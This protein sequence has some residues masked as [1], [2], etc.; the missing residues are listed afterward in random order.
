MSGTPHR[1]LS[2][3]LSKRI[4]LDITDGVDICI[5]ISVNNNSAFEVWTLIPLTP[6][7]F[8]NSKTV[9]PDISPVCWRVNDLL[10]AIVVAVAFEQ[11]ISPAVEWVP[12]NAGDANGAFNAK[13]P[14]TWLLV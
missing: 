5:T 3:L 14:S 2:L 9:P 7:L 6:S 8:C 1:H 12:V 4:F 11:V 13:V 10:A